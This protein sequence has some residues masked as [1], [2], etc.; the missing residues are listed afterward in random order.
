MSKIKNNYKIIIFG[1]LIGI[2][3][4]LLGAGGGMIA[5]PLLQNLGMDSKTAHA[6]AVAVI[7]PITVISA[8]MY[9]IKDYVNLSS[10]LIY[11]PTGILGAIIGS[12]VLK[13]IPSK[14]LKKLFAGFMLYAGI[15]LLIR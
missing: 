4:G 9:L 1:I 5:V 2:I 14:L 12:L 15:R 7:L 8:V 10:A 11:I 6:N 13:K 3:N